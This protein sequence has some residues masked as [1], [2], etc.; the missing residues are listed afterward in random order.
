MTPLNDSQIAQRVAAEPEAEFSLRAAGK[1]AEKQYEIALSKLQ[2][3]PSSPS[4][5]GVIALLRTYLEFGPWT[6][7]QIDRMCAAKRKHLSGRGA[8]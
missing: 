5:D 6:P 2:W 3:T 7:E 8:R 1:F 4:I